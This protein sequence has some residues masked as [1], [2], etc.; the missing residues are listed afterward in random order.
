MSINP[1]LSRN[2]IFATASIKIG[3][4]LGFLFLLF[5]V[6]FLL[7]SVSFHR[8]VLDFATNII[9]AIRQRVLTENGLLA[10]NHML[11]IFCIFLLGIGSVMI[12]IC[13]PLIQHPLVL[14]SV[15]DLLFVELP[16]KRIG[17]LSKE[18]KKYYAGMIWILV[19]FA[20]F[21]NGFYLL[22][23]FHPDDDYAIYTYFAEAS[24]RGYNPYNLPSNYKTEILD[25]IVPYIGAPPKVV[26][27]RTADYPPLLMF[28]YSALFDS[29]GV[30]GLQYA[31][32]ISFVCS[33][34][35]YGYYITSNLCLND[36]HIVATFHSLVPFFFII[37]FGFSG[38]FAQC[39]FNPIGDKAIFAFLILL[40]I[41]TYRHVFLFAVVLGFVASLKWIALPIFCLYI[42]QLWLQNKRSSQVFVIS[43]I[44]LAIFSLSH[45]LYY[46]HCLNGYNFR[47]AHWNSVCH[48]S[49]FLYLFKIGVYRKGVSELFTALGLVFLLYLIIRRKIATEQLIVLTVVQLFIFNTNPS[50]N[51]IL[52]TIFALSLIMP[53]VKIWFF[54]FI[55]A[56]I[57]LLFHN[58]FTP[59]LHVQ[60]LVWFIIWTWVLSIIYF[61]LR[62]CLKISPNT[63]SFMLD[64]KIS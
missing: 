50:F 62:T 40:M 19:L 9:E 1:I 48:E 20:V 2:F 56:T 39:W 23:S 22:R 46:P 54:Q 17:D 14:Q 12:S 34:L 7:P 31:F 25:K 36:E 24:T 27:Q 49:I 30:N 37:F 5:G 45:L 6:V 10:L 13:V 53:D 26:D 55:M 16:S 43:L 21:F 47:N 63:S 59:T 32:V 18:G 15:C 61:S 33:M 58:F 3:A 60:I 51:R 64:C 38:L 28:V 41:I 42:I 11:N 44:F 8:Y 4:Y 35:L 52:V 29:F 57:Y